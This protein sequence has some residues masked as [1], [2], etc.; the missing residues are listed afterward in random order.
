[1]PLTY[2]KTQASHPEN[3]PLSG[4]RWKNPLLAMSSQQSTDYYRDIDSRLTSLSLLT[5]L[6]DRRDPALALA[7]DSFSFSA[8]RRW[9]AWK[10]LR[11]AEKSFIKRSLWI[12]C[13]LCTP[14]YIGRQKN[15]IRIINY[16]TNCDR[17]NLNS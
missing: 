16:I 2:Q 13:C 7:M 5:V 3:C 14:P 17:K 12:F 6:T 15:M 4:K 9:T 10:L 8:A 11:A 1:M